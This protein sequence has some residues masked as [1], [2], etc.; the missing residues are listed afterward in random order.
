MEVVFAHKP[1]I[2]DCASEQKKKDPRLGG[3]IVMRWNVLSN[4]RVEGISCTSDELQS[5][6]MAQCLTRLIKGWRFPPHSLQSEPIN[7]PFSF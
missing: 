6:F 1:A 2:L 5:S 7:F 4:G 3:K